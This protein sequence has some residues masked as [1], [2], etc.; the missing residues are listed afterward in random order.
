MEYKNKKVTGYLKH[1]HIEY[2]RP[3]VKYWLMD[4]KKGSTVTT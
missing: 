3:N 4:K 2:E 1:C